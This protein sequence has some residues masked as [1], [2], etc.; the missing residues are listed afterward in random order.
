[1]FC[2]F[3]FVF[4]S[5]SVQL[6]TFRNLLLV[7]LLF[8]FIIANER[9]GD[10]NC[11]TSTLNIRDVTIFNGTV[12]CATDGGILKFDLQTH[13]F[14][15]FTKLNGLYSTNLSVIT[16]GRDQL[17]WVGGKS[18]GFLQRFNPSEEMIAD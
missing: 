3:Y 2:N 15:P 10:W 4:Y 18:P 5:R 14:T 1:M 7:L 17:L 8:T 16:G 11:Y 12:Y 13:S 9:M 6:R